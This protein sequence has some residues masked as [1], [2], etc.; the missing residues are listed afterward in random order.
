[1]PILKNSRHEKFCLALVRGMSQ[2]DAAIEAGY[3]PKWAVT[4]A[5][6]L[7]RKDYIIKRREELSKLAQSKTIMTVKQRKERLSE[8]AKEP[9]KQPATAREVVQ[10]IAELNKMEGE[11]A[12]TKTELTGK[13]GGPVK[14]EVVYDN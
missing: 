7:S 11:Y 14:I 3:S 4:M 1:M 5:H 13:G 2:T 9:I 8:L 6:R 10:S 12:P